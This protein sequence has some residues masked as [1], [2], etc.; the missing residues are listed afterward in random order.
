[1]I[2]AS[3]KPSRDLPRKRPCRPRSP[4]GLTLTELLVVVSIIVVV[5]GMLVPMVTPVLRGQKV[6]EATRQINLLLSGSQTRAAELGRPYGVWIERAGHENVPPNLWYTAYKLF[7]AEQPEP[8]T[9]DVFNARVRL[10]PTNINDPNFFIWEAHFNPDPN[11]QADII[12]G[13]QP[14][15]CDTVTMSIAN[16]VPLVRVGDFIRFEGRD[17][18]YP[19]VRRPLPDRFLFGVPKNRPDMLAGLQKH[20]R[21]LTG[22]TNA[23]A[24]AEAQ[25]Y[26]RGVSFEIL[27]QPIKGASPPVELPRNTGLDLSLS[28]Y[29][30]VFSPT[31]T[32]FREIVPEYDI[33]IMFHPKGG[34][35]SV[36]FIAHEPDVPGE[37]ERFTFVERPVGTISLLVGRD[38]KIGRDRR[39]NLNFDV[40]G[41]NLENMQNNLGGPMGEASLQDADN[42]WISVDTRTG[43]VQSA[44][45]VNPFPPNDP[46]VLPPNADIR[47]LL[48]VARQ[49]ADT[50]IDQG[51]R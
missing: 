24:A 35:D 30:G 40:N 32:R 8:Y 23:Q 29:R 38:D 47:S 27:R 43:R 5:S 48:S 45:N 33:A 49:L 42:L 26:S 51:G 34:V 13:F 16:N 41:L 10:A 18:K 1:M 25:S 11:P 28:G 17:P 50:A 7:P 4:R 6:R 9:G 39:G 3:P 15:C 2:G 44:P 31:L 46:N 37:E 12:P 21:L 14:N 36:Y 20:L 22:P 19:I